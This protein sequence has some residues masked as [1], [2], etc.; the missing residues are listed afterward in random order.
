M[1]WDAILDVLEEHDPNHGAEAGGPL[2]GTRDCSLTVRLIILG[3]WVFLV[4][5]LI[6]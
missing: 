3:L 4:W 5:A 2:W 6:F 1:L